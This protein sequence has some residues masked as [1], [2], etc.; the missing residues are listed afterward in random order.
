[1]N[2]SF[3]TTTKVVSL[4][5]DSESASCARVLATEVHAGKKKIAAEGFPI[6]PHKHR[7]LDVPW[8][9]DGVPDLAVFTLRNFKIEAPITTQTP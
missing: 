1:V 7:R 9:E 2:A 3:D 4:E 5:L 8:K 6:Y